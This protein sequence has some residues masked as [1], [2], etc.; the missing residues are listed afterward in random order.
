MAPV[1]VVME[2]TEPDMRR[3]L[4]AVAACARLERKLSALIEALTPKEGERGSAAASA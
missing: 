2:K 4:L 3:L 1:I